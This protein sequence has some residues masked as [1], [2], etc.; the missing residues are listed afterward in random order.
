MN[1]EEK[2]RINELEKLEIT[3]KDL[4]MNNDN[5]LS[6]KDESDKKIKMFEDSISLITQQNT[7]LRKVIQI[8]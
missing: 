8:Y 7:L 1:R 6:I 5:F 2:L 3:L 4:R